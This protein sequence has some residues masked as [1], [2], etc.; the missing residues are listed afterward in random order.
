[1]LTSTNRFF[2]RYSYEK[3]HRVLPATLPHGDAGLHLRRR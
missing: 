1:M 2:G 3:T